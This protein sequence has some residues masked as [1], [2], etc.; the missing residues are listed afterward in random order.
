MVYCSFRRQSRFHSRNSSWLDAEDLAAP[1]GEPAVGDVERAIRTDGDRGRLAEL[2]L[3]GSSEHDRARASLVLRADTTRH[4]CVW[5]DA[6]EDPRACL[7]ERPRR[8]LE[9]VEVSLRVEGEVDDHLEPAEACVAGEE[10]P[11]RLAGNDA[12]DVRLPVHE[13]HS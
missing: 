6:D 7:L 11:R 4:A 2:E 1:R 13:R 8:E 12:I 10:Q 3:A 5:G 9:H